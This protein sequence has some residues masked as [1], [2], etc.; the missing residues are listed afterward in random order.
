M[1]KREQIEKL[2]E[3]CLACRHCSIGG[4]FLEGKPCNVL[5]NMN[6]DAGIMVVGQNPGRKEVEQGE[7]F[8]GP[9]GEFFNALIQNELG[10]DR[11][12]FYITNVV[13]CYTLQ[14]RAPTTE[15]M[16]LCRY[17]LDA[18][19]NVLHPK[20]IVTLGRL[21]LNRV[22]GEKSI[23]RVH[24]KILNSLRYDVDVLPLFHPSPINTNKPS[25]KEAFKQDI[26]M[27]KDYL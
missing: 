4:E 25:Y 11:S 6:T 21:A 5:S 13:R 17:Y 15:E 12:K 14:N 18:E 27:L 8:V 22:T 1:D 10:I 19:V 26:Q 3:K 9:S 7:P 2:R 16:N 23:T 24:G 20:L